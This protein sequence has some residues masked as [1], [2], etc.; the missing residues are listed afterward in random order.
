M[1]VCFITSELFPGKV[2]KADADVY[3][4]IDC[5]VETPV[6][7]QRASLAQRRYVTRPHVPSQA[8]FI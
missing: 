8:E 7:V 1:K 6:A 4:F 2:R 3:L 5:V